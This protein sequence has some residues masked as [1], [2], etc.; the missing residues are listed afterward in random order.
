MSIIRR[1][2]PTSCAATPNAPRSNAARRRTLPP[3]ASRR[4]RRLEHVRGGVRRR[5]TSSGSSS[6]DARGTRRTCSSANSRN[7]SAR[8]ANGTTV[9]WWKGA[10]TTSLPSTQRRRRCVEERHRDARVLDHRLRERAVPALLEQQHEIDGAEAEAT[11]SAR[12]RAGRARPSRRWPPRRPGGVPACHEARTVAGGHS[13]ASMSRTASRNA[14][15][16]SVNAN[17]TG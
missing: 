6:T 2:R 10:V 1:A 9:S 17:R 12:A 7:Q 16:S 11:G 3:R 13:F 15:W 5:R 14:S 4:R 8:S